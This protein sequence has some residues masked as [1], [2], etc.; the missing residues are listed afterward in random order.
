MSHESLVNQ[1]D[2][3][4]VNGATVPRLL[5][6]SRRMTNV[7]KRVKACATLGLHVRRL[8]IPWRPVDDQSALGV[9][10]HAGT[11]LD[12]LRAKAVPYR[13]MQPAVTLWGRLACSRS[14]VG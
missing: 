4:I 9:D 10:P 12:D 14:R 8:A 6:L 2:H 13:L 5:A 1:D 11:I 7:T 3:S